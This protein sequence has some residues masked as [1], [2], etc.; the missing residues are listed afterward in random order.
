[1]DLVQA[2]SELGELQATEA[3]RPGWEESAA[4]LP[5]GRPGFLEPAAIRKSRRWAGLPQEAEGELEQAAAVIAAKPALKALAW[6]CYCRLTGDFGDNFDKWPTLRQ[7]LG[8]SCG[9][10]YLLA[11]LATVPKIRQRHRRMGI[12]EAITANSCKVVDGIAMNYRQETGR[13]GVPRAHLAWCRHH[14]L[15][16]IFR[17]GRMEYMLKPFAGPLTAYRNRFDGRVVALASAGAR[18]DASGHMDVADHGWT[19][20]SEADG[21]TVEGCP[22]SPYGMAVRQSV[23]LDMGVWRPVLRPGDTI[24][25]MHIPEGG[26]MT[27]ER[28]GESMRD[29]FAFFGRMFPDRPAAAIACYSWILNT[30]LEAILP[31]TANLVQYMRQLYL[32]P[33][34]AKPTTGFYFIFGRDEIDPRTAPR[35]TSLQRA[36]ADFV[37]AGNRWRGGGMFFLRDELGQF[38]QQPYRRMWDCAA[39]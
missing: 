3:V 15:G 30:Q 33:T 10:F 1:M 27:L 5:A 13:L 39:V 6:H 2:L 32:F 28:C 16:E 24:M 21:E 8:D 7:S 4:T 37:G 9:V 35:G 19:A 36:V 12:A 23:R 17:I 25:E 22:I 38:G 34:A 31:A 18:F 11:A 26:G 14:V 29:G 20:T